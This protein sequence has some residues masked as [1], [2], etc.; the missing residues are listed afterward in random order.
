MSAYLFFL[1]IG[2]LVNRIWFLKSLTVHSL[3]KQAAIV[4]HS[5]GSEENWCPEQMV[6]K[7]IKVWWPMDK[8]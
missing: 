6:R 3:L 1:V 7:R 2:L 4:G 5:T 8:L